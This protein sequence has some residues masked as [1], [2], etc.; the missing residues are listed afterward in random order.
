MNT[1]I[2]SIT[3]KKDYR[4]Y[5]AGEVV[6]LDAPMVVLC[7]TNGSGKSTVLDLLRETFG[8]EDDSYMKH[9]DK[10]AV[11]VARADGK[12]DVRYYDFHSGDRK[13][14]GAFGDD[15]MGQVASMH[16]SS[17][18]GLLLQFNNT[19][20]KEAKDSLI[21]LDEP[22]RGLAPRVQMQ[23]E[24]LLMT[25]VLKGNQVII[26]THSEWLM[27]QASFLGGKLYSAEHKKVFTGADEFMKAHLGEEMYKHRFPERGK[28]TVTTKK[29][30]S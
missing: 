26:A 6:D 16:Q 20:I 28:K 3:F 21:I 17:G 7:G 25:L 27:D 12:F 1:F 14:A 8:I 15:V 18:I 13:Y 24:M 23:M 10:N 30:K 22:C 4:T 29:K 11:D 2:K 19:K 5:K 9:L